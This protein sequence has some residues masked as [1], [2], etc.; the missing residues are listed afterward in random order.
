MIETGDVS[1]CP[2]ERKP[3][4]SSITWSP[5]DIHTGIAAG[6]PSRSGLVGS[7]RFTTACPYSRVPVGATFP[8]SV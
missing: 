1:D 2:I 5:C 4:G 3:G 7:A 8:P 6:N